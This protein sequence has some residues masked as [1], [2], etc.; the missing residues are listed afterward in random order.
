MD[1]QV[2]PFYLEAPIASRPA[3][4][5]TPLGYIFH[6]TDTLDTFVRAINPVTNAPRWDALGNG[7]TGMLTKYWVNV[8]GQ[9]PAAPYTSIQDAVNAAVAD[10]HG[11]S[12]P[13][14]VYILPGVY[15]ENV[16]IPGGISL[17]G[18][19]GTFAAISLVGTLTVSG[20][21]L[22]ITGINI[23]RGITLNN[24]SGGVI[25]RNCIVQAAGVA[26]DAIIASGT[27]VS[28]RII[29]IDS[30]IISLPGFVSIRQTSD[31]LFDLE[32][33]TITSQTSAN[34]M[35][36]QSSL[37]TIIN[38]CDISGRVVIDGLLSVDVSALIQY[39]SMVTDGIDLVAGLNNALVLFQQ[40]SYNRSGTV[41]PWFSSDSATSTFVFDDVPSGT[42]GTTVTPFVGTNVR[43]VA[44]EVIRPY[45]A[46]TITGVGEG[47]VNLTNHKSDVIVIGNLAA[48][49]TV[50]LPSVA[51]MFDGQRYTI[52]RAQ[53]SSGALNITPFA[54]ESIEGAA[55]YTVAG[56][57][58]TQFHGVTLQAAPNDPNGQL[59]YI[60]NT[61]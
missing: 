28:S 45:T 48:G 46:E 60:V 2:A 27:T 5:V 57:A 61:F 34:S 12:H 50:N 25:I 19:Q 55:S 59:W 38:R 26:R 29:I 39:C 20:G 6:A 37:K 31:G 3:P 17:Y 33:C 36:F 1:T 30:E 24:P 42:T 58:G 8:A 9:Q 54:G 49:V 43:A 21:T 44:G 4:E 13:A 51:T 11:T 35:V 47:P 14:V 10:G 22:G 52:K 40:N 41:G 18:L 23:V 15:I 7:A 56:A 32:R 16:N 53:G